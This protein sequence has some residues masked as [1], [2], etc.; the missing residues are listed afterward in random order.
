MV[1]ICRMHT[2]SMPLPDTC[3]VSKRMEM[4]PKPSAFLW[5]RHTKPSIV[6]EMCWTIRP[7]DLR[8]GHT[9]THALTQMNV[10][11]KEAMPCENHQK[12]SAKKPK[13]GRQKAMKTK[14]RQDQGTQIRKMNGEMIQRLFPHSTRGQGHCIIPLTAEML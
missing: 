9:Y 5:F 4:Y 3:G 8:A 14:E 2:L 6:T 7:K 10:H 13:K 1:R 12:F 11:K